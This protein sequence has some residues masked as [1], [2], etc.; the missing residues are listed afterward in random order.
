MDIKKIIEEKCNIVVDS[1][2]L[3]GEGYDGIC[4]P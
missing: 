2:K 1:I 4:C 3:I